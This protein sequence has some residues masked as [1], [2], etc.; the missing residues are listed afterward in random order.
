MAVGLQFILIA[1]DVLVAVEHANGV[2]LGDLP[3]EAGMV[4]HLLKSPGIEELDVDIRCD[5]ET[6]LSY[7]TCRRLRS[8]FLPLPS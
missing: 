4:A 1:V 6:F 7:S 2:A 3:V 5:G 8:T